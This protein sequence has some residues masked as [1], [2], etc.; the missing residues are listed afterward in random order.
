MSLFG[1]LN[2][3]MTSISTLNTTTRVISDN[4][5][6]AGN[7]HYNAREANL[8]NLEFGGVQ[9]SD[10]SRKVNDGIFQDLINAISGTSSNEV[11]D[12]IYRRIEQLIGTSGNT[13]PLVDYVEAF[14]TAWKAFEA[15]PES[16]AAEKGVT[17]AADSLLSE[18]Q[19]LSDGLDQIYTDMENDIGNAVAELNDALAEIGNLNNKIVNNQARNLPVS[20]LQNLRD[21]QVTIV[22][23]LMKV[24]QIPNSDGSV[25]LYT[26]TGLDLVAA[27]PSTFTWNSATQT[28]TK[29][30]NSSTDLVVDGQ[31]TEG[32][33]DSYTRMLRS[34]SVAT[35]STDGTL[36][37][38]QKFR[39]QLDEFAFILID[40][41]VTRAT[42]DAYLETTSNLITDLGMTAGD[43][44][45]ISAG[46]ATAT[47]I[48]VAGG[49]TVATLLASINAITN[50]SARIDAHGN[51][52]ILTSAE[53]LTVGQATGTPLTDIGFTAGTYA[54]DNPP[55]INY[56]YSEEYTLGNADLSGI[57]DLTSLAGIAANDSFDISVAGGAT[58]TVV[59]AAGD[60]T[61]DLLTTL[62]GIDG[63][64][65]KLDD[66]GFLRISTVE[67]QL[68]IA[69]NVNTP[70]S[71]TGL[72]VSSAAGSVTIVNAAQTGEENLD[73]FEIETGTALTDASRVNIRVNDALTNGTSNL[74]DSSG[75]GVV[76]SLSGNNR[77]ISGSGL[78]ADNKDYT[79][80]MSSVVIDVTKR[81]ERFG[82]LLEQETNVKDI[83]FSRTR[84]EVGVD[85]D[86][87]IALLTVIQNSY[88]AS[89]R[90]I[91]VI[92]QMFDELNAAVR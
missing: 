51:L 72:G 13:T 20:N 47:T 56:A 41:S 19:R 59:I 76:A 87:E 2:V 33:I 85:I 58:T 4:I 90:V 8:Q 57:A 38:I 52:Q 3:A 77:S 7:D 18:M 40:D 60:S 46:G 75:N 83:L 21:E 79:S 54:A 6:N 42:G 44:I 45:T 50:V 69:N 65:A 17:Q 26:S 62:N 70:L 73:F 53:G 63:V 80:L 66:N 32:R 15:A 9:V 10:I 39:N 81:S 28:L 71:P 25:F 89:A 24:K 55:T 31:L 23:E 29:S 64:R 11:Y 61:A 35:R 34:D 86:E 49:D 36:A 12:D 88:A 74:K 14:D 48:T 27:N 84:N 82:Q 43:Q 1:A 67:G 37:P 16:D 22:A 5:A 92:G 68:T 30:G 78:T 91:E